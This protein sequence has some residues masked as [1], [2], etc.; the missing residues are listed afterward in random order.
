MSYGIR[1]LWRSNA[2]CTD[3]RTLLLE[4]GRGE[5]WA[6]AKEPELRSAG[7]GD[8][9]G[10]GGLLVSLFVFFQGGDFDQGTFG[11]G[12]VYC[13]GIVPQSLLSEALG[14]TSGLGALRPGVAIGVEC[15][16][17]NL[18]LLTALFEFGGAVAGADP[19]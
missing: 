13:F 12:A 5:F 10:H 8:L 4:R 9:W 2:S 14:I 7:R 18:Q 15:H 6:G 19:R 16:A 3:W 11:V 1:G 17:F